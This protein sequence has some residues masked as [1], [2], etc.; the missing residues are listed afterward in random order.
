MILCGKIMKFVADMGGN[1]HK[2]VHMMD[3]FSFFV[4]PIPCAFGDETIM[5]PM[6]E[7]LVNSCLVLNDHYTI[8]T[9]KTQDHE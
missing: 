4:W 5:E 3:I 8:T 1:K 7:A 6:E 2:N 9:T